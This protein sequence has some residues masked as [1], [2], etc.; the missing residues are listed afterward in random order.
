[1]VIG[2]LLL[3]LH[4]PHA[5]SLKD[6]RMV[7]RRFRDRVRAHHNV[8]V[9]EL[10]FQDL[11]QRAR[12]GIVT[13]NSQAGVVSDVLERILADAHGSLEEAVVAG[14]EIRYY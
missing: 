7:L 1:M 14:H 6:K 5:R 8:A 4:F 2:L 11:W 3:E 12:L 9:S 13:L 10:E